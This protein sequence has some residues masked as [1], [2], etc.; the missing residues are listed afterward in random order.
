MEV[1]S[2]SASDAYFTGEDF[3]IDIGSG[4]VWDISTHPR[5]ITR[6]QSTDNTIR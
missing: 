1:A 6:Y 5:S 3:K 2:V 4:A